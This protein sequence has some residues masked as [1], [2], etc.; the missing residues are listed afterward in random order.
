MKRRTLLASVAGT[1][2]V[3]GTAGC[4]Q[5]TGSGTDETTTEESTTGD[6]RTTNGST[7]TDEPTTTTDDE[8]TTTEEPADGEWAPSG[9]P[10]E[11]FAVGDRDGVAFPENNRPHSIL[12]W[13][14]SERE[15]EVV[16]EYADG[17]TEELERVGPTTVPA[18]ALVRVDLNVPTHYHVT[19]T[20]D[21]DAMGEFEIGRKWFDCNQSTSRYALGDG[22]LVD[23]GEESTLVAC[24]E[25]SVANTNVTVASRDCASEDDDRGA[26]G[27]GDERIRAKGTVTT[28]TPCYDLS[29]AE[30]TYDDETRTARIVVDADAQED[31][32]C[33]EC[34]GAISYSATVDYE[35]DFPDHVE[36]LHRTDADD[37]RVVAT[38]S[39][40]SDV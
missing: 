19:V 31:E 40:N 26:V 37:E 35:N 6:E 36:L 27:Y 7:D 24:A 11:T 32:G 38:A 15:R 13:N 30:T 23:Y 8:P 2:S 22:D 39:W 17:Q 16:V 10:V 9:E 14:R 4:L 12:L 25:P 18:D 29:I 5:G 34:V 3:V 28:R 20:V 1:A 33:V 21:G